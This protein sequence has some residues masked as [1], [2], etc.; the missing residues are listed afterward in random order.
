MAGTSPAMTVSQMSRP[1]SKETD[2][3]PVRNS[4]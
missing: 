3:R 1:S 2:R 4:Q